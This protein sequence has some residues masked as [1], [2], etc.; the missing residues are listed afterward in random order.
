MFIYNLKINNKF[1]TKLFIV[2]SIIIILFIIFY[3]IYTIFFKNVQ[4]V[5]DDIKTQDV[6]ELNETNYTNV[7]KSSNE[8]I[9]S[10]T[11]LK[12]KITGYVYRILGFNENQFVIARDMKFNENSRSISCRIFM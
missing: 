10:Y 9:D 8:D 3:C 5:D 11:G 1:I 7:L 2:L 4:N 12:V 6:Y